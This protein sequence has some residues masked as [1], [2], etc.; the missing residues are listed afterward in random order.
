MI[1][2]NV[3][4]TLQ[5]NAEEMKCLSVELMKFLG[6][7]DKDGALR[8]IVAI[9]SLVENSLEAMHPEDDVE[10]SDS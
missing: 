2:E 6:R 7:E 3:L 8:C 5:G 10:E 9:E 1:E 4:S